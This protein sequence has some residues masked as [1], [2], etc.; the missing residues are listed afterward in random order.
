MR[1][2]A[3]CVPAFAA[4][5]PAAAAAPAAAGP[6]AATVATASAPDTLRDPR[7][8]HL[9]NVRQITF[10]GENAEAYW[11]PDGKQ[12]ILQ[13][14]RD[15][16]KCDHIFVLDVA[17]GD[18][19]MV[20]N[21]RGRTTCAYFI[22]GTDR[23]LYASTHWAAPE[24]PPDPDYSK[25]YVW[26]L[27]STYE[28]FTARRDGSDLRRLT[29]NPGYD[30]EATCSPDGARVIFTSL[31]DGDLD[32]YTMRPDGSDVRR[33]TRDL[34]YDGGAF[35]SHDG[36]KIVWRASRPRTPEQEAGY[37]ELL[38]ASAIRPMALEIFVAD[39]DGGNA[40]QLTSN[41]AA[42]FCPYFSPD[43][44]WIVFASNMGDPQGRNFD[45]WRMRND[46]TGLEQLTFEPT[47]D[48][49][50]MFSPDGTK[51]VFASNR[52]ARVRG[53]TNIFIADWVETPGS[54]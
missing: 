15:S 16:L 20:S 22:P 43:D 14:K 49:F 26:A 11:S 50:P 9:R 3:A 30:A 21:G 45:L 8:V 33:I 36:K 46:G 38:Q 54:D 37:R 39:A 29:D 19:H 12:L 1:L 34:G 2:A 7:E 27:Y 17:T 48:G 23:I 18:A 6:T 47:F 25:G 31:R 28:I 40:R 53:D 42:N 44:R 32:L 51:L 13:S 41:G 10:G 24:C 52:K 35:Y 5:L 4:I